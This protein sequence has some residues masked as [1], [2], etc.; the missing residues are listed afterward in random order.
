M[1]DDRL[2]GEVLAL[3]GR[4]DPP[5]AHDQDAV[6]HAQDLRQLGRDDDHR[7]TLGGE[8]FDQG[9]DLGLGADIDA[10][11]RLVEQEDAGTRRD[12]AADD[13]LLLVAA[14][15]LA[16]RA[17]DHQRAKVHFTHQGQAF[18]AERPLADEAEAREPVHGGK[19]YVGADR[20]A[21]HDPIALALFR[22]QP[23]AGGDGGPRAAGLQGLALDPDLTAARPVDT[24]DE[25]QKLGAPGSDETGHA[26]NL[27]L[28]QLEAGIAYRRATREVLDVERRSPT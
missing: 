11:R 9:V 18:T 24:G 12:P 3:K 2:F 14:A 28:A 23:E 19:R 7:A 22:Q 27:A 25:P 26:E 21:R 4:G 17:V 15:E 5:L 10:A 13:R 16:D 8:A 6:G 1:G 20:A